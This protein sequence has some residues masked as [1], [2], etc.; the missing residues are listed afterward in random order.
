VAGV[1]NAF[2]R[3]R[4]DLVLLEIDPA[5]LR[6]ALQFESPAHPTGATDAAS[7]ERFPHVYGP[8]D[9]DAVVAATDFAPGADGRFVFAG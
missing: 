1:A 9:L 6:S 5:R 8:I 2:Y 7:D 3:G 4:R